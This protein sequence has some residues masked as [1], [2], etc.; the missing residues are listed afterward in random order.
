MSVLDV[1]IVNWNDREN[2]AKALD[3]VFAL[4][5]VR[6]DADF[7]QVIVSDN[8]SDDGSIPMLKERYGELVHVVKNG[9]NLGFGAGVNRAIALSA[10]PYIFLLNPDATVAP[11][12][13]QT[14]VAFM[15]AHPRCAM[16]GPK[17]YETDGTVAESC[18]EF[19]SWTGAFLR[20]SAWGEF[21]LFARFA[22]GAALRRWDYNSERK[23]D[24]VIGAA[25]LLRRSV[26]A[27]IGAFDERYFMYHEEIDL[28]KRIA[29]AGYE[30]WFVPGAKATHVGQGSSRGRSVESHKQRSRRKYWL[31]HHGRMWYY[32]LS[33]ALA[34]RYL[35]YLA[36][37]A[38]L[39]LVA[40]HVLST[41]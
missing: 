32:T 25:V 6:A 10:S 8:G 26:I 4:P 24:L 31:K 30:T 19:D 17:T 27:D 18:G 23:V 39:L 13:L 36:I 22:N 11:G 34:G 9:R 2:L 28:A 33:A 5:E 38:G 14:L 35:L 16:A 12:A 40:R 29:D 7:A 1:I 21:P 15:E 20:S 37:A 3:S 41:R